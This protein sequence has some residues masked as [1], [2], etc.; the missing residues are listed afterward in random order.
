MRRFRLPVLCFISCAYLGCALF[1][2]GTE[3]A[4]HKIKRAAKQRV[5]FYPLDQVWR[6]AHTAL[7]YTIAT[8]NPDTGIIETEYIKGSDGWASPDQKKP[9]SEGRRYRLTLIMA[10]GKTNGRDSTRVTIDKKVET[11]KDF[12]SDSEAG[13]SDGL[14]EDVLFYRMQRELKITEALKKAG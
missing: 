6:A 10:K 13:E 3:S 11:L 9:A 5:F 2:Q 14:E 7:K 1:D 8:E 12:F 4:D